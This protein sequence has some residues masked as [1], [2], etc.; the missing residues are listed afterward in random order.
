M[1]KK[2]IMQKFQQLTKLIIKPLEY[3][4]IKQQWNKKH[5]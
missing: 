5:F 2:Q 1:Q 3:T 4:G